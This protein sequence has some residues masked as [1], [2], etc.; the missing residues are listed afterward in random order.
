MAKKGKGVSC[1]TLILCFFFFPFIPIVLIWNMTVQL[2]SS[3]EDYKKKSTPVI[4]AAWVLIICGVVYLIAGLTGSVQADNPDDVVFGVITMLL[5]CC[6]GGFAMLAYCR[7]CR[8]RAGYYQLYVPFI[9]SKQVFDISRL[10]SMAGVSQD[11]ALK[12]LHSILGHGVLKNAQIDRSE[13]KIVLPQAEIPVVPIKIMVC[14][15][16]NGTNEVPRG[17]RGVCSYCDMPLE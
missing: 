17:T 5:V 9:L 10:A 3:P 14:P 16:C 15:H 7:K 1:L 8:I 13:N 4:I 11:Q 2:G 12:Q 6:G